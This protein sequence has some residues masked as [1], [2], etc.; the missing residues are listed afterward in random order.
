M[1]V[2]DIVVDTISRVWVDTNPSSDDHEVVADG[3]AGQLVAEV[4]RLAMRA[5]PYAELHGEITDRLRTVMKIDAACWHGLDPDNVLITTANPVELFANGF[6]TAENE[7]V[8]AGAVLASEYQ[9]DDVNAFA[10]RSEEHTSE[11]QSR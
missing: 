6:M 11:L 3:G 5:L 2:A 1:I 7:M 4:E 10:S 8:G 9:R